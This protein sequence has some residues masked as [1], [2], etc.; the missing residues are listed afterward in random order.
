[1]SLF[2]DVTTIRSKRSLGWRTCL[3]IPEL[4]HEAAVAKRWVMSTCLRG[5][6]CL[7]YLCV[8]IRVTQVQGLPPSSPSEHILLYYFAF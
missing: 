6:L 3:V 4:E 5:Y 8:C 7:Y 1:M 2:V